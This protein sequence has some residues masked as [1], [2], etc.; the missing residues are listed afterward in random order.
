MDWA[1]IDDKLIA[2]VGEESVSEGGVLASG[3]Y[4]ASIVSAYERKSDSGAIMFE[5]EAISNDEKKIFWS[6]C[7]ASGDAKG[8]KST[9]IDKNGEEQLLPGIIS[10]MRLFQAVGLDAKTEKPTMAK[11]ERKN[12]VID[13]KIYKQ[14]AGK[15]FTAC[16]RQYEN[17]YN[18]EI[19]IKYDIE[20]F[21]DVDGKNSKGEEL[22]EK[23]VKK[24]E[25]SPLKKL[26]AKP[27]S[28]P[29]PQNTEAASQAAASG[30]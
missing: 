8:N 5:L 21:L 16:I 18:G 29:Q 7:L 13:A 12:T 3:A 23:F 20:H 27:Q 26:K 19:S 24:I 11:V 15:K 1:Q 25:G 22:V 17:L 9:Y 6:T 28:Q 14:L 30:W 4:L 2:N 10:F